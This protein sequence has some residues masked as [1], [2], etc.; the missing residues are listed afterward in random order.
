[1]QQP[2]AQAAQTSKVVLVDTTVDGPGLLI[3]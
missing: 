3:Q 1:M 2:L